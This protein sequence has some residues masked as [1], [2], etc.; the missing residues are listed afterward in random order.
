[1]SIIGGNIL[2]A[3]HCYQFSDIKVSFH[4]NTY[5][6]FD[7]SRGVACPILF[8]SSLDPRCSK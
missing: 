5:A 2:N 8:P 1:M 6:S 4:I 7:K 3:F